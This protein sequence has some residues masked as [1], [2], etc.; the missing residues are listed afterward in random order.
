M[1]KK[2][3]FDLFG[4]KYNAISE[5]C[6]TQILYAKKGDERRFVYEYEDH[7]LR[8]CADFGYVINIISDMFTLKKS[9]NLILFN[10]IRINDDVYVSYRFTEYVFSNIMYSEHP[11]KIDE[12]FKKISKVQSYRFGSGRDDVYIKIND[13]HYGMLLESLK[14]LYDMDTDRYYKYL[15]AILIAACNR[16]GYDSMI[17]DLNMVFNQFGISVISKDHELGEYVTDLEGKLLDQ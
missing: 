3:F 6:L 1:E 13:E 4:S 11:D 2:E 16:L 17:G 14:D 15:F 9:N 12:C 5:R 10:V 7:G 8:M